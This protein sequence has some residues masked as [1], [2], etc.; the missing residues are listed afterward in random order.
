MSLFQDKSNEQ[1]DEDEGS[2]SQDG[3]HWPAHPLLEGEGQ[4]EVKKIESSAEALRER[5]SPN[6]FPSE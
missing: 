4:G 6:I 3:V 1:A 5:H 2:P